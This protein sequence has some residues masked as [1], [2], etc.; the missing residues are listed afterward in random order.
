GG[1]GAAG[2]RARPRATAPGPGGAAAVGLTGG[3]RRG[4]VRRGLCPACGRFP[5]ILPLL[6]CTASSSSSYATNPLQPAA[7]HTALSTRQVLLP[8]KPNEFDAAVRTRC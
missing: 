8:P 4:R 7:T 1:V 2:R 5:G 6:G 3:F